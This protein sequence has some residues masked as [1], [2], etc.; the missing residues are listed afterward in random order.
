[1]FCGSAIARLS[2][3]LLRLKK[4]II[5]YFTVENVVEK[6]ILAVDLLIYLVVYCQ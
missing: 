6:L 4:C 2:Y 1:M 3:S 5:Y